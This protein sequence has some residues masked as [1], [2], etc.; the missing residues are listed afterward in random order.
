[1]KPSSV[2]SIFIQNADNCLN[3]DKNLLYLF[4]KKIC[5]AWRKGWALTDFLN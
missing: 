2:K 4:P 3:L 5:Q 1:M